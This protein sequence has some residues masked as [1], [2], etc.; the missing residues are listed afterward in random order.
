M[1]SVNNYICEDIYPRYAALRILCHFRSIAEN[2]KN[3]G[4]VDTND[5]RKRSLKY[6]ALRLYRIFIYLYLRIDGSH[7]SL[8]ILAI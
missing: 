7:L 4:N 2:A 8:N 1:A 6:C 3:F 5:D